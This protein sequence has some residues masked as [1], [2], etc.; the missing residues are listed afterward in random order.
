MRDP[1]RLDSHALTGEHFQGSM[2]KLGWLKTTGLKH[3]R[4]LRASEDLEAQQAPLTGER[5][6]T[7]SW[8]AAR[9]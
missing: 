8:G 1:C 9:P 4:G 2:R 7:E 6:G 3:A 5:T